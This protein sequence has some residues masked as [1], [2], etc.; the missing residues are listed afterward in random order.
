MI[1]QG[2]GTTTLTGANTYTGATTVNA[3]TLALGAANRIADVSAVTVAA[4]GTFNL[5][6]FAETVGS[7]AGAGNIT[8]GAGTLTAGGNNTS[9]TFSGAIGGTTGGLTKAGTGTL[10]LSGANTYGGTTTIN[11]G[12]LT[13]AGG[14][15]IP[16]ASQVT[17][18]N[19][20]GATLNL[21]ASETVG[22]LSGG[23]ALGGNVALGANTLTVNQTAATT[24]TGAIGGTGG[25][26][27]AGAGTLTLS[28][29]NGYTGPTQI[30]AGTLQLGAA[31]RIADASAVTI[32]AGATFNLA[33]NAETVGSV[34]GA[35][36]IALGSATLTTGVDNTSTSF[37]GVMS[38]AGG[39]VKQGGGAFTLAGANTYTGA[40]TVNAGNLIATNAAALGGVGSGTTVNT[41][42]TLELD[43]TLTYAEPVALNGATLAWAAGNPTL[44]GA[45]TLTGTNTITGDAGTFTL[46]GVVGGAGGFDKTGAGTVVVTGNNTYAGLTQVSTGALQVSSS[47]GLGSTAAG[48]NIGSNARLIVNG[49]AIGAEPVTLNGPG[50]LG[51]GAITS[52][53]AASLAG[54]ITL[55]A[56]SVIAPNA[57][58]TLTL[59]GPVDGAFGLTTGGSGTLNLNGTVGG[60]TPLAFLTTDATGATGINAGL[61]R[62]SGG[63]SYN[64]PTT[65]GAGVTLQ[66]TGGNLVA[67]APVTATAGA[68]SLAAVG[69]VTFDNAANDLGTV[70]MAAGGNAT[71]RDANGIALAVSSV[72]GDLVLNANGAVTQTGAIGVAGTSAVSAGPGPITLTGANDFGGNVALT[73]IGVAQVNDINA[74]AIGAS[75]VGTLTATAGAAVTLNG[76][77]VATDAGS[78]IVL[79]APTFTNN[80]G[81]AAL[82]AG[83]GRWLVYSVDPA[84][85]SFGGLASGNQALWNRAY[86]SVVTEAGN[87]YVFSTQPTLTFTST[88]VAKT[89]GQDATAVVASAFAVSGFVDATVYGGV[90]TQDTAANTY[91]GAPRRDLGRFA[92][93]CAGRG[94][95]LSDRC[96]RDRR[97]AHHRL[98]EGGRIDWSAHGERGAA[99]GYGR[100]PVEGLRRRG[101][102]ADRDLHRPAERGDAVG[103]D[104]TLALRADRCG[105]H[106][107]RQPP[108][109]HRVRRERCQLHDL[110]CRRA[111]HGHATPDLDRGRPADQGLRPARSGAHVRDRR[112]RT[113]LWRRPHGRAHAGG[114]RGRRGRTLRDPAGHAYEH[115]QPELRHRLYRQ[116]LRDH[117]RDPRR[118]HHGCEQGVRRDRYG[119]H[120]GALARGRAGRRLGELRRR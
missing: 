47:N 90:F 102:G 68:L 114:G 81:A 109:D 56:D 11:A 32:A 97:H 76:N 61:V 71:L 106:R 14:S 26:T 110:V 42:A 44:N 93:Y 96:R 83:A 17:L 80:A 111:A 78:S 95:A 82:D 84:S 36:T 3:G 20:A 1:Q 12:T 88:D 37:S 108:P 69:S 27:K 100:R 60:T 50:P 91:T 53:G 22:N 38:G 65:I 23:G 77:I 73:T 19:V 7:I 5:A 48:T 79:A 10:T 94:L 41:G 30:N 4:G 21:A 51:A 113:R 18:T 45:V 57:G 40:T 13:V 120:H 29:A 101:S 103:R 25:L 9:T 86:P 85:N 33:N 2:T 39:L 72:G 75:A 115:G 54:P 107:Y 98:R 105:G 43:G 52:N 55:A 89:Y 24:Y 15:A 6:G 92:R 117:A 34:A 116:R 70:G 28:G 31:N 104:R 8:L 112:R 62:T 99:H 118:H 16:D 74:L 87:R 64:N 119:D 49:A 35:G 63:Q 66:S 67:A 46:G 59:A 58:S